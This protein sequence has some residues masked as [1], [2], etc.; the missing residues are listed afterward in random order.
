MQSDE[1]VE[2]LKW[3]DSCT[4]RCTQCNS[5]LR[6]VR[7]PTHK[8]ILCGKCYLESKRLYRLRKGLK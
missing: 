8:I 7:H 4:P 2:E 6:Y 3:V 1:Y 5:Y